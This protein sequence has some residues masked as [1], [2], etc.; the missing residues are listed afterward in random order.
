[1]YLITVEWPILNFKR[2]VGKQE[3]YQLGNLIASKIRQQHNVQYYA[4]RL[5]ISL[6]LVWRLCN[7]KLNWD[8]ISYLTADTISDVVVKTTF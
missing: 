4:A 5:D 3:L 2:D 7:E 6:L 1:M 8:K